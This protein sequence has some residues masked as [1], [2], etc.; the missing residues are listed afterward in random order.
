[1]EMWKY[2]AFMIATIAKMYWNFNE[3]YL[4]INLPWL[5]VTFLVLKWVG[6]SFILTGTWE[7]KIQKV[8]NEAELLENTPWPK[9]ENPIISHKP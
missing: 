8:K 1:M 5:A 2:S 4:G 6:N 3:A 9:K 7:F